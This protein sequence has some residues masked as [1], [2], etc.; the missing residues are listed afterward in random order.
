MDVALSVGSSQPANYRK[1]GRTPCQRYNGK[2]G[3]PGR[4]ASGKGSAAE[5]AQ[6]R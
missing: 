2:R 5:W 6:L 1:F 4:G 3:W